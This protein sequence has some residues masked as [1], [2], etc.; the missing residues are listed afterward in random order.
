MICTSHLRELAS[1]R[2]GILGW[3]LLGPLLGPTIGPLLGGAIMQSLAW[4]WIFWIMAIICA[5]N[6]TMGF[7]FLK[8][9]CVPL[10]DHRKKEL[11]KSEGGNYYYEGEDDRPLSTKLYHSIQRP[12]KILFTQPIVLTMASY[13]APIFATT[14]SLYTQMP[15]TAKATTDTASAR[16]KLACFT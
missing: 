16:N 5:I 13:Q 10:L 15:S 8:E 14:Y 2:A 12:I 4:P 1:E 7:L 3:Y 11:E 9:T 6:V